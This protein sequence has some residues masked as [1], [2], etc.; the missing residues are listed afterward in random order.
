[1]NRRQTPTNS[2][3]R[4]HDA[5]SGHRSPTAEVPSAR[6]REDACIDCGWP[7]TDARVV[8]RH[9]TSQG[10]VVWSRCVC[11]ALQVWLHRAGVAESVARASQPDGGWDRA[12]S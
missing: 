9:R 7:D 1:M 3:M 4:A 6:T 2:S 11:G 12:Q 5:E 10:M 8:S